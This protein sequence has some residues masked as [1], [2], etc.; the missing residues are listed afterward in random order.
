MSLCNT[1]GV[2]SKR[3]DRHGFTLVE[4]IVALALFALIAVAGFTLLDGV[5]RAQ[6]A[7]E[8]RLSRLAEVQ[9]AML[10]V[11]TDLDQ[12][13][14]ALAGGGTNLALQKDDLA[15]R[16]V[17]VSY[18]LT[19]NRLSRTVAGPTGDRTQVI[20]DNVSA[21]RWSFHERRGAWL[22][23][24]PD[25]ASSGAAGVGQVQ[26]SFAGARPPQ[27]IDVVALDL[28]LAGFDGRPGAT[29]RRLASVP[30]MEAQP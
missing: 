30:L 8:T 28:S 1:T 19:E 26:G 12:I 16:R 24:W 4:V 18:T 29:L 11:S 22:D 25:P 6:S 27:A 17:T 5:L 2:H 23:A 13:S 21:V 10:V 9:R 7:T 20:L 15:G 3:G 14:G